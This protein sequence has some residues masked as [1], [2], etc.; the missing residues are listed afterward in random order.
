[1]TERPIKRTGRPLLAA[2][3]SSYRLCELPVGSPQSR[4]AARLLL[5]QRIDS[6]EKL[7][8]I[9][10]YNPQA[11]EPLTEP[12]VSEWRTSV[13]DGRLYRTIVLPDEREKEALRALGNRAAVILPER[14]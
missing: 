4:A 8:I 1:M 13:L 7:T 2:T 10:A 5:G 9:L 3:A 14:G 12:S 11:G 6:Q